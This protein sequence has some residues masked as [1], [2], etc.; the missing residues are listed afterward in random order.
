MDKKS[1]N[2]YLGTESLYLIH[3]DPDNWKYLSCHQLY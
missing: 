1:D 3:G 2:V